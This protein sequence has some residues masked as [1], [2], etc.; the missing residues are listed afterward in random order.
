MRSSGGGVARR[1]RV[2]AFWVSQV[3]ISCAVAASSEASVPKW[4]GRLPISRCHDAAGSS[5]GG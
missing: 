2:A 5:P 4:R 1:W 3:E